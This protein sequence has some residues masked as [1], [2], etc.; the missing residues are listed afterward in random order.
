MIRIYGGSDDLC[1]VEGISLHANEDS[2]GGSGVAKAGTSPDEIGCYDLDVQFVIGY[3]EARAGDDAHGIRVW[4]H[5]TDLG[6]WAVSVMPIEE[7]IACRFPVSVRVKGYSAVA[8]IDAPDGTPV[9]YVK[10]ESGQP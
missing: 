10:V 1:E 5:Y 3:P 7:D 8:E 2:K 4:L 6:V 9:T